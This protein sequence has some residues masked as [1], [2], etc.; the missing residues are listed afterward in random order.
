LT[1]LRFTEVSYAY[2]SSS[3]VVR[4]VDGVS[5]SA[6]SGSFLALVGRSGSGKSTLLSLACGLLG[7]Q[8]G[9]V[10]V[11]GV[12]LGEL[13]AEERSALRLRSIGVVF[14]DAGLLPGMSVADNVALPLMMAG[15][16]RAETRRYAADILGRLGLA[17]LDRRF[18]AELSGGQRQRISIARGIAGDRRLLLVDEPTASLDEQSSASVLDLMQQAADSGVTVVVAT[19]DDA[20]VERAIQVLRLAGGRLREDCLSPRDIGS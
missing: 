14:Q 2:R 12:E 16:G 13:D 9:S 19:H 6:G 10:R 20:V 15:H 8:S 5:F 11:G 4:V 17:D 18:P 1:E 3:E 7:L